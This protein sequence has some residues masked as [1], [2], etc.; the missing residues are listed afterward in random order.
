MQI[1]LHESG[2]RGQKV[3]PETFEAFKKQGLVTEPHFLAMA[4]DVHQKDFKK[5][6]IEPATMA[7][8]CF[9]ESY[10]RY[11]LDWPLPEK[12]KQF[13]TERAEQ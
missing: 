6:G 11:A 7:D 3:D 1:L 13:W 2:H 10:S 8:E 9:A 4:N 5:N 12:I